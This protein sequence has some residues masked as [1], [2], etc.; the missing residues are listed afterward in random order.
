VNKDDRSRVIHLADAQGCIPGP[1]GAIRV[2]QRGTL[3]VALSIAVS[4]IQERPHARTRVTLS[5]AAV[6]S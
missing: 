5:F 2:L 4:P 3:D 1:A 6:V